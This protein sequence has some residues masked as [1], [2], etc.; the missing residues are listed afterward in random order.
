MLALL[1]AGVLTACAEQAEPEPPKGDSNSAKENGLSDTLTDPLGKD[2]STLVSAEELSED[3]GMTMIGP[4]MLE[5]D[6]VASYQNE[7]GSLTVE[8]LAE[9]S[10]REE[11]DAMI[12]LIPVETVDA[13]NLGE[14][15][16]WVPEYKTLY[17]FA[18]PYMTSVTMYA[19]TVA[20][21]DA[22]IFSRQIT[23]TMME[24]L[25]Q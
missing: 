1:M 25:N 7:V 12:E 8:L 10:S 14:I 11:F 22:L 17:T 4:E 19:D 21:A 23:I 6:T 13:P 20:R 2:L 5:Y 9:R 16:C 3:L 15:S 24:N 18:A